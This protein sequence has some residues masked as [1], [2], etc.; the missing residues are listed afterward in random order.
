MWQSLAQQPR[1]SPGAL[2]ASLA[3]P[4]PGFLERRRP[5]GAGG[6]A[7]TRGGAALALGFGTK[8]RW[9]LLLLRRFTILSRT[10]RI[11]GTRPVPNIL[12]LP[13]KRYKPCAEYPEVAG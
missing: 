12:R 5:A 4:R 13:D 1:G 9:G 11:S 6:G 8:P 3:G 2:R 7:T 10:S